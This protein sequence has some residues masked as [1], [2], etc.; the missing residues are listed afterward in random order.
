[1]A[2][3]RGAVDTG[4]VGDTRSGLHDCLAY[5]NQWRRADFRRNWCLCSGGPASSDCIHVLA[6]L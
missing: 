5:C 3:L 2:G 1:M 4:Q 6:R